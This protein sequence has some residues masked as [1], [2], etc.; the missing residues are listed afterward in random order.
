MR[1]LIGVG[2]HRAD[3]RSERVDLLGQLIQSIVRLGGGR[4]LDLLLQSRKGGLQ[5][6]DFGGRALGDSHGRSLGG[7]LRGDFRIRDATI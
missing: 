6:V 2:D 5:G 1:G 3:G 4:L 7:F